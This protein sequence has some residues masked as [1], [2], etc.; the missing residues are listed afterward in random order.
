MPLSNFERM[1][2]LVTEVFDVKNDPDQLDVDQ[3]VIERLH[4]IHPATLSAK[5][6]GD[7]PVAWILVI[8]TTKE[9]MYLFVNKTIS[10]QELYKRTLPGTSY[11]AVYLCSA[12]VLSEYRNK[13]IAQALLDKA[14]NYGRTSNAKWL[15]LQTGRENF[16]AQAL[17]KKNGWERVADLFYHFGLV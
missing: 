13:G 8:P 11:D 10:E 2:Q 6:D 14:K 3:E 1:M 17:Y 12:T 15:M 16:A 7:G 5:D 4:T 9:L